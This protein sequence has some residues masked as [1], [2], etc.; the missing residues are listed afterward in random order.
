MKVL[1]IK[2][3]QAAL[4]AE[5]KTGNGDFGPATYRKTPIPARK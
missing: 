3:L 2:E 5:S 4:K 1:L